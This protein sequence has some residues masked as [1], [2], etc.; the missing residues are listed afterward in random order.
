MYRATRQ[1]LKR[2]DLIYKNGILILHL[3]NFSQPVLGPPIN[4][5]GSGSSLNMKVLKLDRNKEIDCLFCD[6]ADIQEYLQNLPPTK[7]SILRFLA[8]IFDLLGILSPFSIHQKLMLQC[9]YI[10]NKE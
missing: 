4:V 1:I 5:K 3:F 2:E 9:L 10:D 8:R 6:L 7:R